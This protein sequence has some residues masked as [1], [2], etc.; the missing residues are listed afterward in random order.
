LPGG[1]RCNIGHCSTR[2]CSPFI[3][4]VLSQGARRLERETRTI[5]FLKDPKAIN[6]TWVWSQH[7]PEDDDIKSKHVANFNVRTLWIYIN[8]LQYKLC[9]I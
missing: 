7:W 5:F 3:P 8:A 2:S 4:A 6:N 9:F 1:C